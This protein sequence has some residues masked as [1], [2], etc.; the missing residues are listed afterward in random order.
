MLLCIYNLHLSVNCIYITITPIGAVVMHIQFTPHHLVGNF[1]R[2]EMIFHP[3]AGS[4]CRHMDPLLLCE[5]QGF[6]SRRDVSEEKWYKGYVC[7]LY[8]LSI[9]TY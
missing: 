5:W 4:V 8:F 2:E 1:H 7:L 9:F 3:Q 6:V